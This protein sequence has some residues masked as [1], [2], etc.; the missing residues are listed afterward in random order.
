MSDLVPVRDIIGAVAND[1]IKQLTQELGAARALIAALLTHV[2][3]GNFCRGCQAPI[4]WVEHKN[5]KLVPYDET[6]INHFAT[7]P[8]REQFRRK[9]G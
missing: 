5:G 9:K 7:C 1:T 6:G 3:E 4:W 8:Q 2:G